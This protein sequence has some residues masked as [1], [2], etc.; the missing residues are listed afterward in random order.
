MKWRKVQSLADTIF[1]PIQIILAL[2]KIQFIGINHEYGLFLFRLQKTI[3]VSLVEH[4]NILPFH[5]TF[6]R[7]VA[8]G[9][10]MHERV[11]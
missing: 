3:I 10:S 6:I 2:H 9:Y 11:S 7:T 8:Q 5:G 1:Y 4:F